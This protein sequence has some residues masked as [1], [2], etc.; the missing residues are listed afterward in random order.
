MVAAIA[1]GDG[2]VLN[3]IAW[4]A[5]AEN[6]AVLDVLRVFR[7]AG[8]LVEVAMEPSGTYGDVLQHQLAKEGFPIFMVSGKRT[9]DARE[10]YDGVPSLHDAKSAAI[11][12]RLH[13]E[14]LSKPA[15]APCPERRQLHAAITIMD[16][17]QRRYLQLVGNLESLLARHWPE[18]PAL[19]ELTAASLMALLARIGGPADVAAQRSAAAKLLHGMSHGLMA[20]DKIAAILDSAG[21][22]V[23]VPLVGL[24]RDALMVIAAEAHRALRAFKEAKTGVEKLSAH[25]P[26]VALAPVVGKTTAAVIY[27]EVGDVRSFSSTGSFLKAMGLNLKEKSSGTIKGQLKLTKRGSSRVRHYLWLAVFRWVQKDPI[28]NAW[29]QRK[30]ERDGGKSSRAAVALMRKLAKAL[31]YVGRGATFDS[32]KLFDVRRLGLAA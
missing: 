12:A 18:L 20:E 21:T 2:R 15:C 6:A 10:V 14:G 30:K 25:T 29:Y 32:S 13:G 9:F 1:D 4:K 7:A 3:T 5:P 17:H 24:E 26:A 23:G 8:F 16:L 11:I 22:S 19:I 28:A 31:Y 27:T